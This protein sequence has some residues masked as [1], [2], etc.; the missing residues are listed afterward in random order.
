MKVIISK[1]NHDSFLQTRFISGSFLQSSI[2]Q[3]LLKKQGHNFWQLAVV[4]DNQVIATCL[5]Y[6]NRLPLSRSY[7]YAPKGPIISA[8]LHDDKKREVLQLILSRARDITIDTKNAQEIF[9]KVEPTEEALILP[10][11]VKTADIQPRDNWIIDLTKD[12]Q[13]ILEEMHAK[14][15]YNIALAKRRGVK[16]RFSHDMTDLQHFLRLI[17]NTAD[18][19]QISLLPDKHY[20]LL[21]ATLIEQHAGELA[22]AEVGGEVVAANLL[23]RFGLATTYLHGGTDYQQ[24]QYMAPQ[25]LQWESIKKA[26]EHGF[27][28]YDFGGVAPEDGSKPRWAGLTR[29]KKGFGGYPVV[30]PGAYDLIYDKSWYSLYKLSKKILKR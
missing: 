11:L 26:K 30:S 27:T 17:K 4:E 8:E 25:L 9:F 13:K 6:E 5:F 10:E 22:L 28:K 1:D 16:I 19:N 2:W 18:R 12:T 14:T 15:R 29:F 24:R 7:F 21:L 23:I 20:K 3:Q